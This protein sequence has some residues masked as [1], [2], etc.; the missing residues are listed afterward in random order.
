M[1]NWRVELDS[2]HAKKQKNVYPAAN[3][4]HIKL[5]VTD[6]HSTPYK[7]TKYKNYDAFFLK[8]DYAEAFKSVRTKATQIPLESD[9]INNF[10]N[11][12]KSYFT[13]CVFS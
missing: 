9:K 3:N 13:D 11:P 4:H 2:K 1:K 8:H 5:V 6:A 7:L 10:L 12:Y